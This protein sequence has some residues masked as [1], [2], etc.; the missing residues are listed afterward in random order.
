[1]R[2]CNLSYFSSSRRGDTYVYRSTFL[3]IHRIVIDSVLM[4]RYGSVNGRSAVP[5][6]AFKNCFSV[7]K[8][9]TGSDVVIQTLADA[10]IDV[11]F[12]N[13]GTTEM[14][15]VKSLASEPRV[16]PVLALHE[17]ICSGACD[18]YAR[19][20]RKPA[21]CLLHMGLGL[22]NAMTNFHNAKK[23]RSPIVAIVGDVATWHSEVDAPLSMDIEGRAESALRPTDGKY[24]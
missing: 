24:I 14:W 15:L 11:C 6:A 8:A 21:A 17:T 12:V 16:R 18:G 10:G 7:T 19:M 13:P 22:A 9:K 3:R 20:R 1:M 5:C 4:K 2:V 23:A